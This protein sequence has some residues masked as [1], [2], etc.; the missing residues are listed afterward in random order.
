MS[1]RQEYNL[2][3]YKKESPGWPASY[4]CDGIESDNRSGFISIIL[5][6]QND[7]WSVDTFLEEIELA[8]NGNFQDMEEF[9]QP[10][11]LTDDLRCYITPP[12][13][14]LGKDHNYTLPLQHFKEFLLEWK[15]FLQ[16]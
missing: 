7:L 6:R 3:F 1:R 16:S 8:E 12:N 4:Y 5:S 13:I 15:E 9:W 11:S 14:I 10:D 2:R